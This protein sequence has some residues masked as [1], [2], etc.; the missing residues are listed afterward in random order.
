[1]RIAVFGSTGRVGRILVA[2]ALDDGHHV[3]AFARTPA[4]LGDLD[5]DNLR[6]VTGELSDRAA[7]ARAIEDQDAVVSAL[8]PGSKPSGT[9]LSD[10]IRTVVDAMEHQGVRRLVILSTASVRDPQDRA[11]VVYDTLT[12]LIRMFFREAYEE[13]VAMS[14]VIRSS[15]VDWTLVRIGLLND[16]VAAPV[17]AGHYGC[18]EVRLYISR[19]SLAR[20]M[21]DLAVGS[22]HVREAPAVSN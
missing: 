14:D 18:G 16:R 17:L 3:T 2:R 19:A 6:V 11:D 1:V 4:K 22:A 10:G 13:I 9:Q 5:S 15:Q 12:T 21:L 8:G 7:I 20:Y